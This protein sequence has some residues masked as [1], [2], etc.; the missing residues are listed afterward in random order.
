MNYLK[1]EIQK[2]VFK[3]NI[4]Y[5]EVLSIEEAKTYIIPKSQLE[6][7]NVGIGEIHYFEKKQNLKSKRY[8]LEYV[9]SENNKLTSNHHYYTHNKIYEFE[10]IN[11]ES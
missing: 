3:N 6:I 2:N 9:H 8:F 7:N 10:I 1:C 11:F 4:E 5:F